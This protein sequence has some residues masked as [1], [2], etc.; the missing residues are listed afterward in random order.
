MHYAKSPAPPAEEV[1]EESRFE[2]PIKFP[3]LLLHT[4]KVMQAE[5]AG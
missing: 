1:T 3:S 4:L 5:E 2:S